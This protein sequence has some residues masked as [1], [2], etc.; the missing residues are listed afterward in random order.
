MKR[1]I[2]G[3][4]LTGVLGVQAQKNELIVKG[5]IKDMKAGE[6]VFTRKISDDRWDSVMTEQG[7][8]HLKL[9]IPPG[10][11]NMYYFHMGNTRTADNT[12]TLYCDAGQML[13]KG[14]GPQFRDIKL[15]GSP[16]VQDYTAYKDFMQN[17]P[18]L[19]GRKE[20][21]AKANEA[22]KNGDT[23]LLAQLRPRLEEM[24][25]LQGV[26]P[27]QW[28]DAHPQSAI[29]AYVLFTQLRFKSLAEQEAILGKLSPAARNNALAA[30]IQHSIET[31]KLTS[32]GKTALDFTQADTAGRPIALKDF[33]GKYVLVDFWASWC[34]PCRAENPNVVK[35]F[36]AYKDRN[37]TVLGVS[38]DQPN[39]KEKWLKAINDDHLTWTHV[40]DLKFWNNAVAKQYEIESIPSNMLIGPDG[41]I[42]AKDLHGD[43]LEKKL[44]EVL[45][46][47]QPANSGG[48]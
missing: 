27:G 9:T 11:G 25:S 28:V 13:M 16:F 42:L 7:G 20:M 36:A 3:I 29:S 43:E 35:A 14:D 41:K 33:R 46:N 1:T 37:F 6:W 2:T 31:A 23:L 24:D 4:L 40:S 39:G 21:Y 26:F 48:N 17:Q 12:V 19:A 18:K 32:I 47:A 15:S 22:Y 5:D 30:Q 38:L 44:A 8:F 45:A 34:G 10:E